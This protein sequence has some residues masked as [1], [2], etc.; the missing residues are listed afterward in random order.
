[1]ELEYTSAIVGAVVGAIITSLF[2]FA[3]WYCGVYYQ[4]T[5]E[6][7]EIAQALCSDIS[8]INDSLV[9]NANFY[10]AQG[11]RELVNLPE[12]YLDLIIVPDLQPI[13]PQDGLYYLYKKDITKFDRELS[14]SIFAFYND[15]IGAENDRI[16]LIA[17]K[18]SGKTDNNTNF[19]MNLLYND[20]K[21]RVIRAEE[22]MQS[23][24]DRLRA[25]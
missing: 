24:K 8:S 2:A 19:T 5:K 22:N 10:R 7:H 11:T 9:L 14:E 4:E 15:L 23:L 3:L 1:M 17:L 13:Y 12:E 20:I 18:E 16:H 25:I 21:Q 6:K